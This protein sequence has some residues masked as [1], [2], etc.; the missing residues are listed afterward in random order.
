MNGKMFWGMFA[1]TQLL[2]SLS[3]ATGSPHGNPIGLAAGMVLLFPGSIF[4]VFA[5]DKLGIQAG[6]I[7]ILVS[8]VLFLAAAAQNI[9]REC[10]GD[11][12]PP[13]ETC[14]VLPNQQRHALC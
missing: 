1:V 12:A 5:I 14:S 13:T 9:K 11:F 8:A 2:G 6:Y 7:S 4:A 10:Y 3:L